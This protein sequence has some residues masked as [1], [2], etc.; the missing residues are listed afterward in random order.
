[1]GRLEILESDES[2]SLG[3]HVHFFMGERVGLR[4]LYFFYRVAE[5]TRPK[6]AQETILELLIRKMREAVVEQEVLEAPEQILVHHIFPAALQEGSNQISQTHHHDLPDLP[7]FG[8]R[9]V[10][11]E[12]THAVSDPFFA[13]G[14][15]FFI[16]VDTVFLAVCRLRLEGEVLLDDEGGNADKF[17]DHARVVLLLRGASEVLGVQPMNHKGV[18]SSRMVVEHH[19]QLVIFVKLDF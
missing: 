4:N 18:L 17:W 5:P 13:V 16:D 8:S 15:Y 1:M 2:H 19:R 9:Q 3:V 12:C 14:K 10:F 11:E 6:L 7:V